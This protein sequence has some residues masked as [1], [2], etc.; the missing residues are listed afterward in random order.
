MTTPEMIEV[1]TA[2]LEGLALEWA[3]AKAMGMPMCEEAIQPDR[4]I[5]GRG[6]GDLRPF[7]LNDQTIAL[8][9]SDRISVVPEFDGG[10]HAYVYR[11]E[12][13]PL[14]RGEGSEI[15]IAVGRAYVAVEL[16]NVVSIPMELV[17]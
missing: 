11:E 8:M 14:S 3:L 2:E 13:E 10:W 6:D 5:V 9:K 16:G 15:G 7:E 4:I 12:E 1:K 17:Q